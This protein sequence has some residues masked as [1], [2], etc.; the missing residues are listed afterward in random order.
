LAAQFNAAWG[1]KLKLIQSVAV[2]ATFAGLCALPAEAQSPSVVDPQSCELH[3][4][5]STE[6]K[7]V[8]EGW[9]WNERV[10]QAFNPAYGGTERPAVLSPKRQLEI[11]S[12]LKLPERL[13]IDRYRIVPHDVP[14]G[15]AAAAEKIRHSES[16]SACYGEL[17]VS[18]I[19][20]EK[21]ALSGSSLRTLGILRLFTSGAEP[22]SSFM[23]WASHPLAEFPAKRA[24]KAQAA[25]SEV[26][27]AFGQTL[28]KFA[29][30][31][32]R[33]VKKR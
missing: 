30:F 31:A 23:T 19:I 26:D 21:N 13:G 5:P 32:V 1:E 9:I 27:D 24:E 4:W 28:L 11:I 29:A 12:S 16:T 20:F 22:H 2:V 17:L 10:N 14:L 3:V 7:S 15:R 33:P 18:Q 6:L 8:T 25:A